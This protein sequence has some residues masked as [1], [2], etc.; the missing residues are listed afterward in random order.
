MSGWSTRLRYRS[1]LIL[2]HCLATCLVVGSALAQTDDSTVPVAQQPADPN[3]MPIDL[4]AVLRLTDANNPTIN[5]ARARIREAMAQQRRAEVLWVPNL[6]AGGNP[7]APAFVPTYFGHFG[8]IQNARGQVFQNI[9]RNALFAPGGVGANFEMSDAI[10]A[11]LVSRRLTQ[12][13]S[14]NARAVMNNVQLEAAITYLDLLRAYNQLAILGE[15]LANSEVMLRNAMAAEK[16]GAGKTPADAPRART[17]VELT[18]QEQI[19]LRRQALVTSARLAQLLLLD[20]ALDLR[21]ADPIVMPVRLVANTDDLRGLVALGLAGRPEITRDRELVEMNRT[22][23]Q[24]ARYE[25]LMPRLTVFYYAGGYGGGDPDLSTFGGRQDVIAQA[26][27]QI[28]NLGMGNV[29]SVRERQAQLDQ[30]SFALAEIQA[31]VGAE[32]TAA[33]QSVRQHEEAIRVAQLTVQNAYETFIRLEKAGFGLAG[34]GRQYDPLEALT[35]VQAL[36]DAR[37]RY[38]DQVINFNQAQFRL[39][40][41]LGRP[42][43]CALPEA[44]TIPLEVPVVPRSTDEAPRPRR[45]EEDPPV[46]PVSR[47]Q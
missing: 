14:A 7:D 13:Q 34:R 32:V 15:T 31:R 40:T 20:P 4:L 1:L 8:T 10:F 38:L 16:A 9:N 46:A 47:A 39:Y 36:N 33:A 18:R 30:A 21:P 29:A 25:P 19:D 11:P 35:A 23:R 3:V 45:Q 28:R 17:E 43:L 44:T 42:P 37:L 12:A 41:A 26:A 2:G 24:Q 5:V 22:R 6:W 27:W